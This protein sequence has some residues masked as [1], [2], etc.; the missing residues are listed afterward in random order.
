MGIAAK[1]TERPDEGGLLLEGSEILLGEKSIGRFGL[2]HP[3]VVEMCGMD[4]AV[5]WADLL[6]KPL[7]K[8]RKKRKIVAYDLPKFPSVRRDLSL[9]IDKSVSFEQIKSAAFETERKLL[10][11]VNLFD[12][13][14]GDKLDEGKVSY[15]ISL[16][17]QD[18]NSTLTDKKIDKCVSRIL[19]SITQK[20][21]ASLR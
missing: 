20:T 3:D 18:P 9:I 11:E 13:Y 5:Y 1:V 16:V 8:A 12:V 2:V 6:V 7:L 15:A 4:G 21:G 10:K 14:E 17:I 19:D